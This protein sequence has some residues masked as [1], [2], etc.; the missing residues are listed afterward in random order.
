MERDILIGLD[1]GTSM[2]KAVAFDLSG[3]QLAIAATPNHYLQKS[4][5]TATQ[6]LPRTWEDCVS[7]LLDLA[8][9]VPDLAQRTA[10][11]SVT[12]QG[13]GTWLVG[14]DNTP[15][16]EGW[17]WLDSRSASTVQRM[18]GLDTDAMRFQATGTGLNSCQQGMQLAHMQSVTPE[19]LERCEAAMHCK[20]WL[21]LNLTGERATDPSE[22]CFTF[23]NFKTRQYDEAVIDSLGLTNHRSLLPPIV[24]GMELQHPLSKS[25]A[26]Q[27]GLLAGTPVCLGYVDVVCTALGAGIYS[28]TVSAGCSILG[29]TGMHMVCVPDSEVQ[30]N[31]QR[32]GYV[33]VMPVS[34]RVSQIQSN[35]SATLNID[36]LLDVAADLLV[37]L[38]MQ[39]SRS[40][41]LVN[42]DRWA[43]RAQAGSLLYHPY[44]SEAGERGPFVNNDARASFIGLNSSH[45]FPDLLRSV[46]EGLGFAAA[47][48]YNAMGITPNEIRL[49]GGAAQ[50]AVLRTIVSAAMGT[51]VRYSARAEA[52]AAGAA[53]MAAVSLGLYDTMDDCVDAWVNPF[54]SE[55]EPPDTHLQEIYHSLFPA[56][57][58][59]R[60][61]LEP[62]WSTITR[63]QE[64]RS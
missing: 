32:T 57:V 44:I 34:G 31:Q 63:L 14:R 53:M 25:A 27:S 59:A 30:L 38:G 3:Q 40:E 12:G 33:M 20:D 37:D 29:S 11:I 46:M 24:D 54:L 7:T 9:R 49:S 35:M 1:S 22:A 55:V 23:G 48:C 51:S 10:A 18:R 50:S 61:A 5:G 56:Y 2:V 21:Y 60:E 39:S 47:D 62:T 19:V 45:R 17:L 58:S 36:W 43:S 26:S 6:P 28:R 42:V 64:V 15:V 4:D 8:E 52:G 16:G 41:L 13:D